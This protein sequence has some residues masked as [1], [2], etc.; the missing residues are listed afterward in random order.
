MR[1]LWLDS[2]PLGG[3]DDALKSA[4]ALRKQ[5]NDLEAKVLRSYG[6]VDIGKFLC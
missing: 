3:L 2:S 1:S 6:M 4:A 5:R